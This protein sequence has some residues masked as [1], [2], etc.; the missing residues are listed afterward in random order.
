MKNYQRTR[1][2]TPRIKP[3]IEIH[4]Y[5]GVEDPCLAVA[6][7]QSFQNTAFLVGIAHYDHMVEVL[8]D[9]SYQLTTGRHTHRQDHSLGIQSHLGSVGAGQVDAIIL[10]GLQLVVGHNLTAVTLQLL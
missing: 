9:L 4:F 7:R 10:N 2:F 8:L 3:G 5:S 1:G 6:V